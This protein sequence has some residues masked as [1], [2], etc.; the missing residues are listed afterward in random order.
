MRKLFFAIFILCLSITGSAS[1][2]ET[3]PERLWLNVPFESI[4]IRAKPTKEAASVSGAFKGE[5]LEAIGRNADGTWFEVSRPYRH[6]SIGWVNR[7]YVKYKFDPSKLP[8]TDATTGVSGSEP[9]EDIGLAVTTQVEVLLRKVPIGN[10]AKIGIVPFNTTVPVI[11]RNID[12]T[13]LR[14]N[15]LG[16]TGWIAGFNAVSSNNL[17]LAPV[18][19]DVPPPAIDVV[20]IP[21]EIQ[22]AQL[23][24]LRDYITQYRTFAD[25]LATF[26]DMVE[27]GEIMPCNP[28]PFITEYKV[29]QTDLRELPELG[30]YAPRANT[31]IQYVNKSLE[32]LT[33]CGIFT[34]ADLSSAKAAA[35]NARVIFDATLENLD[36]LE[37]NVIH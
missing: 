15:Y 14:V 22:L 31:A 32:A 34:P 23:N 28:P 8:L 10:G 4:N 27:K 6:K 18:A 12:G 19:S 5:R 21:P 26:W 16:T 20:I 17:L 37:K 33:H 13:W 35:I 25:G 24:R 29:S 11:G 7:Q 9:I 30:R 36:D 2:Q 1:A 3:K